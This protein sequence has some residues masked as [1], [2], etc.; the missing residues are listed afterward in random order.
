MLCVVGAHGRAHV[1]EVGRSLG[2]QGNGWL[3]NGMGFGM[4]LFV[5]QAL[6]DSMCCVLI[7]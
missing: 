2:S 7:K 5:S 1:A 4:Y 6:N 3:C